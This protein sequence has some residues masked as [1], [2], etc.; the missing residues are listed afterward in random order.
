MHMGCIY[1]YLPSQKLQQ[2]FKTLNNSFKNEIS[3][4]FKKCT[5]RVNV[6]LLKK[7]NHVKNLEEWH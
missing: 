6:A 7:N 5:V 2:I 1:G 3:I 4:P